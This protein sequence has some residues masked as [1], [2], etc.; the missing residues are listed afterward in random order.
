MAYATADE[1]RTRGSFSDT[2]YPDAF[3]DPWI[4]WATAFIDKITGWWFEPRTLES[5]TELKIDG[6]GTRDLLVPLP[7]ISISKVEFVDFPTIPGGVTEVDLDAFAIYN[8]HLVNGL[9]NPDDRRNPRIAFVGTRLGRRQIFVDEFPD[10]RQNIWL[11]GKF[12]Y[13]EPDLSAGRS[14]ASDALDT[15]TAPDAIHMENGAFTQEDVGRRITI[16]GSASNDSVYVIATVVGPKDIETVE[17][18]LTT[19]GTG[20]TASLSAFPQWGITPP[21]INDVAIRLVLREMPVPGTPGGAIDGDQYEDRMR[22]AGRITQEKVRDQ[23]I[24]YAAGGRGAGEGN[25]SGMFTNDPY[26]D[27]ILATHRRPPKMGVF[28]G[29]ERVDA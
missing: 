5:G 26:I 20:F 6:K 28:G 12:G 11:S 17:Q 16:A 13:T 14:V 7:I 27:M 19:E 29:V 1:V 10:G 15:I 18:T 24:S 22:V 3:V 9:T 21:L 8:R 25:I 4:A 2:E 23:S